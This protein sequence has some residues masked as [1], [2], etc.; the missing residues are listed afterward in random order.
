MQMRK[1]AKLEI[2]I[3]SE[4]SLFSSKIRGEERKTSKRAS[5][6]VSDVSVGAGLRDYVKMQ[7]QIIGFALAQR[8][9]ATKFRREC[10]PA[11]GH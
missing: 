7:Q 4:Q 6:T 1:K 3:D 10:L 2:K 8:I 11:T 9:S 5:V